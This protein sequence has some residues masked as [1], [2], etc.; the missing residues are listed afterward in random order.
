MEWWCKILF[1]PR[2]IWVTFKKRGGYLRLFYNG[3]GATAPVGGRGWRFARIDMD[4]WLAWTRGWKGL[5]STDREGVWC[6]VFP[7]DEIT[8]L[9]PH[10]PFF[11][12]TYFLMSDTHENHCY[13]WPFKCRLYV[14]ECTTIW[15]R[16]PNAI[17]LT[18]IERA[19]KTEDA[20]K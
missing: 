9:E 12:H 2:W 16:R 10:I 3:G 20:T 17:G 1:P 8:P 14:I 13:Y 7:P 4:K 19:I 11:F 6:D 5:K 18:V 15:F